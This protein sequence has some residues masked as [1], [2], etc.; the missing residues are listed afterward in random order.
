MAATHRWGEHR[1]RSICGGNTGCASFRNAHRMFIK[2]DMQQIVH[3]NVIV[4]SANVGHTEYD[5]DG[6]CRD[7]RAA[8]ELGSA[9]VVDK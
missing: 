3:I 8:N 7:E 1:A 9:F 5:L 2:E 4:I 6:G